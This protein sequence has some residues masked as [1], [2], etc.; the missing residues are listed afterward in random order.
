MLNRYN[1]ILKIWNY[2]TPHPLY[3]HSFCL[4]YNIVY[5]EEL[6]N[7][8]PKFLLIISTNYKYNFGFSFKFQNIITVCSSK[9]SI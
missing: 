1:F 5:D 2:S 9:F 3:G 4:E 8:Y 6:S 7:K